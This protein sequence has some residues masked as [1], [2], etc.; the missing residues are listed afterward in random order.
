LGGVFIG[1]VIGATLIS[2]LNRGSKRDL[3]RVNNEGDLP[4]F[5]LIGALGLGITG[6][7]TGAFIGS[8]FK[9]GYDFPIE[10]LE[11]ES[12]YRW[13]TLRVPASGDRETQM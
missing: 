10:V 13:N 9:R 1:G 6:G 4:T 11:R 2:N 7:L 8:F 12:N 5:A 3:N